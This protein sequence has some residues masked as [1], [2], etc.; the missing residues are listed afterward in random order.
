MENA[1]K[2]LLMAGGVLIAI[3]IIAI[4]VRTFG[5]VSLFQKQKLTEE[6]ARQ[7]T[8]F[9]AQYTKYLGQYVYGIEVRTL[10]NRYEDDK[11]VQ[12]ELEN[13]SSEPPTGVGQDTKYYKCTGVEYNNST[14]KINKIKFLEIK[15]NT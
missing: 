6:E 4:L 15:L 3:L 10:M 12:V 9:N 11:Q 14:G 8:E 7:I 2:A 13:G 1:S 5:T